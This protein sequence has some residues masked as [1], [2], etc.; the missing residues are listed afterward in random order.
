MVSN[1]SAT[2]ATMVVGGIAYV[3]AAGIVGAP[4]V[5]AAV[6]VAGIVGSAY[7]LRE[8][9]FNV[10]HTDD[11]TERVVDTPLC[12]IACNSPVKHLR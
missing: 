10:W 8:M 5:A 4:L 1:A 2:T 3:A 9:G 12:C 7:L 11:K 6:G